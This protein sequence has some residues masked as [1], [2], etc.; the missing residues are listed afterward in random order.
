MKIRLG[1]IARIALLVVCVEVAAF[2][3]LG[4]FYVDS[5]SKTFDEHLQL[6]MRL[7]GRMVANDELPIN[8]IS[9]RSIVKDL[10]GAP[11]LNGMVI[12]G[13]GRI[14]QTVKP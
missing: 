10:L 11:Y 5:F 9:Q 1:L 12:G 3:V 8:T 7:L 6:R 4:W 14:I 2:G 13:N